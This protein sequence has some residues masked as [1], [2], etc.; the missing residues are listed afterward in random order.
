MKKVISLLL[1]AIMLTL[2]TIPAFAENGAADMPVGAMIVFVSADSQEYT[3][4]QNRGEGV[5]ID[6]DAMDGAA[7]DAASNTLTLTDLDQT[8]AS[9]LIRYMG[10]DF[11][12]CIEGQCALSGI[13]VSNFDVSYNTSLTLTGGGSLTLNE[14]GGKTP[15]ILM[16]ADEEDQEMI[17]SIS[18][19]VTLELYSGEDGVL[20]RN[21]GTCIAESDRAITADGRG[22]E[23]VTAEQLIFYE[24]DQV[25]VIIGSGA[26]ARYETLLVYIDE[27]G[28]RYAVDQN[29]TVYS[30]DEEYSIEVDDN[31]YY[32]AEKENDIKVGD[33]IGT[34]HEVITETYCHELKGAHYHHAA[35]SSKP[36]LL[37]DVDG[38]GEVTILD[39][40]CLQ[41]VLAE[42]SVK[43]YVEAAADADG[44]GEISILDATSIQRFLAELSTN[45]AI[46]EA[47]APEG[48]EQEMT[49]YWVWP[50][51][52][53]YYITTYFDDDHSVL[54]HGA[55]DIGAPM[56]TPVCAANAG[57]VVAFNNS[58]VHNFGAQ[59]DCGGGYGNFV[60]ILHDNGFETIYGHLNAA[61]VQAGERVSAGQVIGYVGS[62]GQATGAHLHFELRINGV[63]CDPLE[64]Y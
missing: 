33:L 42:L 11:S 7:Y 14:V 36:V 28:K 18:P 4:V 16:E 20:I 29:G 41:R 22:I 9:L 59:C 19:S 24:I 6:N 21:R 3:V 35:A 13:T 10:D 26:D 51:S 37:G 40:T 8:E 12:L 55:I 49:A 47:I 64:L 53:Y 45:P 15:P 63:K 60:W 32:I 39:A 23:G 61:A 48:E 50:L 46:G 2:G 34:E 38:D 43:N 27:S 30:F 17:L 25:D 1:I 56:G 44:D 54:S 31:I 57:T 62:T 52:G 58:C 5:E